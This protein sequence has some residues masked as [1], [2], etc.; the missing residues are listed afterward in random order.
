MKIN[1]AHDRFHPSNGGG[2]LIALR[3]TLAAYEAQRIQIESA[4]AILTPDLIG[5]EI[6]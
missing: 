6:R 1:M 5:V 2:W 3:G 4:R